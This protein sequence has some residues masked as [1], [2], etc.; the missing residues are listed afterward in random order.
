MCSSGEDTEIN[1]DIL[2]A[3]EYLDVIKNEYSFERNKKQ[4]FE[5]RAGLIITI[6]GALCVFLFDKVQFKDIVYLIGKPLYIS[7]FFKILSGVFVYIGAAYTVAMLIKTVSIQ[8]YKNYDIEAIEDKELVEDR[9]RGILKITVTY[10][11]IIKQHRKINDSK[12]KSLDNAFRGL[13]VTLVSIVL[14]INLF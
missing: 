1:I 11:D 13:L 2:A 8:R 7:S 10:K 14:Y 3:Q 5:T 12:A 6:L 9:L 4:S